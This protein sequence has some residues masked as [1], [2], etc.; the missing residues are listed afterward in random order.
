MTEEH[1]KTEDEFS[2]IDVESEAAQQTDTNLCRVCQSDLL[3]DAKH[4]LEPAVARKSYAD[5][6]GEIL[7]I[8]V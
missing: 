5:V 2:Q 7:H 1:I 4:L 8:Q 3:P 6:I